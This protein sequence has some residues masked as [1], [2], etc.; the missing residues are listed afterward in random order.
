MTTPFVC[1]VGGTRNREAVVVE[2]GTLAAAF[3]P[4]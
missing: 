3:E 1:I 4:D 2:P